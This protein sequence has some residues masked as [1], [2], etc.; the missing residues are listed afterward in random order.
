MPLFHLLSPGPLGSFPWVTIEIALL[1]ILVV[2]FL[3]FLN[4]FFVASEFAIVKAR[5]SQLEALAHRG[6]KHVALARHVAAHL[7]AYLSATQLGITLASLA[8]G[9]IGEPFLAH[10]LHPVFA[11][12]GITSEAVI[13]SISFTIAF[14][15]ITTLHIVLGELAPKSLAIRRPVSTTL[16]IVRPLHLFH[17]IFKPAIWLLNGLANYIVKHFFRIDPVGG[18]ELAHDE[19]ELRFILAESAK[20]KALTMRG[21]EISMR[22]L[23]LRRI[24]VRDVLT[25]RR[26]VVFLDT[27]LSFTENLRRAK[28]SGHTRFPL[29]RE[30]LDSTIG[31]IHIKDMIPLEGEPTPGL[32]AIK[33]E[34]PTAPEMM[35]LEQLLEFFLDRRAHLA[36]VLDEFGGAVGIVTLDNVIEELVGDI[37]DEFDAEQPPIE[38]ASADEFTLKGRLSLHEMRELTGIELHSANVSTLSGYITERLGHLPQHGESMELDEWV[39]TV[40]N[41]DGRRVR[42]VHFKR[43]AD[44][45]PQIDGLGSCETG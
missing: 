35:S 41:T 9:W 43:R 12:A 7:D 22:A 23:A 37:R 21:T 13:T 25:P 39:A 16:W 44:A 31:L 14:M 8:L 32:L 1:Q 24:T 29:C 19:E 18:H 42:L 27:T 33:R 11:L 38:R 5:G 45:S 30:H 2:F 4:G 17:R 6:E 28:K 34:L 40:V 36:L 26:D 15:I 10:M 20:A 3:V